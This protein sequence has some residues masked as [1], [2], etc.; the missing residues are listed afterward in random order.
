MEKK[1][2]PAPTVKQHQFLDHSGG[3]KERTGFPS[4]VLL[5]MYAAIVCDGDIDTIRT[6]VSSLT[7]FEED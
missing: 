1:N 7:W 6:R 5:L 3:I 2:V 4:V